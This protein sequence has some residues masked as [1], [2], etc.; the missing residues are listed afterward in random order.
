MNAHT[1]I[2]AQ[3]IVITFFAGIMLISSV[4]S[5]G[6]FFN[7][8]N[9]L[10]PPTLPIIGGVVGAIISGLI[11]VLLFDVSTAVW[12]YA[13]LNTAETPQQ[14]ATALTMSGAAFVGAAAASIAHLSLSAT[15]LDALTVEAEAWVSLGALLIVI[16]GV[17]ANFGAAI[18]YQRNSLEARQ[19]VR[20]ADR[21]DTMLLAEDQHR[22]DL[23]KLVKTKT[24]SLLD[25]KSDQ[26][27]NMQAERIAQEFL[28]REAAKYDPNYSP[29]KLADTVT[30]ADQDAYELQR[31]INRHWESLATA[32]TVRELAD[33]APPSGHW[34]IIDKNGTVVTELPASTPNGATPVPLD[35]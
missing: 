13:Y 34:R 1:R 2:S 27:A 22:S 12:L 29:I 19:A 35:Q 8:F 26:L 5:F 10:I 3:R 21:R 4:T 31:Y 9:T 25:A 28:D 17:V 6:F 18:N 16:L 15:Q 23:D 20:E 24:K 7:F 32:D 11:G 14:R 33:I 30:I